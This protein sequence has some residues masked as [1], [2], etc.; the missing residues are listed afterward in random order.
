MSQLAGVI[1]VSDKTRVP[2]ESDGAHPDEDED[3]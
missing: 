3:D 1:D 2:D